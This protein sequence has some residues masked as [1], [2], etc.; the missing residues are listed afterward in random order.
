MYFL[1]ISYN[2]SQIVFFF[3]MGYVNKNK[4]EICKDVVHGE[5]ADVEYG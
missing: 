2:H 5:R 4:Y 3:E 1:C